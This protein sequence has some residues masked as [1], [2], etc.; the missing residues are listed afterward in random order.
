[1]NLHAIVGPC[2]AAVNPAITGWYR[3]SNGYTTAAD[4]T[5]LPA[6]NSAIAVTIQIQALSY[7]DLMQMSGMNING[8][9][10]ALYITGDWRGVDRPD[11]RGGD[12]VTLLDGTVYLVVH[13]LENW[14]RT[15][16][17]TKVAA[18]KQMYTWQD[19]P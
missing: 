17:W 15:V 7:K 14:S 10:N 19:G 1:M 3:A 13:V 8:V 18:V 4:G 16:N 11:Q 9:A 2:V 12:L 6:Y 5:Q